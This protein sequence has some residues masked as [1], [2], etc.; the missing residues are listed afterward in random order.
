MVYLRLQPYEQSTLKRKGAKKL[1]PRFFGP[2]KVLHKKRKEAY[3]LEFPHGSKIHNIFHV[4]CLK[5]VLGRHL[6]PS[7]DLLPLDEEG[8]LT[9]YEERF[10][11][12][13]LAQH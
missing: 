10:L 1:Q 6:S 4:S 8:R 9:I 3:E 12:I 13:W 5:K 2:Y 7:L 11:Y